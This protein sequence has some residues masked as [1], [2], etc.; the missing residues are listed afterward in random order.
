MWAGLPAPWG[1]GRL[2]LL[3]V[4]A[5][6]DCGVG[7]PGI[8]GLKLRSGFLKILGLVL[9][10]YSVRKFVAFC[11]ENYYT[12]RRKIIAMTIS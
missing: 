12:W 7:H 10:C 5:G 11:L 8:P 2:E 9:H 1:N 6:M 4:L 3:G